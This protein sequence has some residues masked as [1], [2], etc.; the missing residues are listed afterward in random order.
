MTWLVVIGGLVVLVF[1]HELGHFGV[2]QLVGIKPRAFYIGFPPA[3][4]KI[5][6]NGIDYAIGAIPLGGLVRIPGMHRPAGRDIEVFMDPAVRENPELHAPTK[7]IRHALDDENW[8]AARAALPEL[9]AAID[10][11]QLTP[12]ASRSAHRAYREADE[13][14]GDDA[15][16]RQKTW[17]RVAVIVAG[18]LMNVVVAFAIF[19]AVF[20][21]G[22]PSQNLA[23]TKVAQV[24]AGSPAAVSG[25]HAG[26]RIVAV[27]GKQ[28]PTFD[29]LSRRIRASHGRAIVVTVERGGR[30]FALPPHTTIKREGRWIFGFEPAA[31]L[32][33]HSFGTSMRLAAD[34]C[35]SI[36]RDT[37]ATLRGLVHSKERAQLTGTVGIVKYSDQALTVGFSYYLQILGFV[38]MS[39]ALMNLLPF[40]PLDGGHILFSIIEGVRRRALAREVYERVSVVGF[41]LIILIFFVTLNNDVGRYFHG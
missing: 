9:R 25:L 22:A 34:Q 23:S 31:R 10:G 3:I 38:S 24:E 28:T 26:D 1:L 6:H 20:L 13:G 27:D 32:V 8:A 39:L 17:K 11:S 12:S 30:T 2:A 41:S 15:Y 40:L 5:R 35:W 14:T 36:V 33:P 29:V 16:W 7:R 21:T 18:P 37:G 19:A 4:A